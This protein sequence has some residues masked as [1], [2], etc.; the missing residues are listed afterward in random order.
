VTEQLADDLL[1]YP[2]VRHPPPGL[3]PIEAD[4]SL[5]AQVNLRTLRSTMLASYLDLPG[6]AL[7]AGRDGGQLPISILISAPPGHDDRLLAA[8]L[9]VEEILAPLN[10]RPPA[11]PALV[12]GD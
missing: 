12:D 2:T 7:P 11:P 4:D 9:T 8:A 1:L 6:V 5:F 3:A 10:D